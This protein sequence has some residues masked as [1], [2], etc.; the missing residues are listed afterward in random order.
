MAMPSKAI[1]WKMQLSPCI[2]AKEIEPMDVTINLL[3]DLN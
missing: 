1:M 3:V 2:L